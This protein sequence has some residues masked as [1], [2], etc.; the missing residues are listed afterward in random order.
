MVR[1]ETVHASEG[2]VNARRI[3][4]GTSLAGSSTSNSLAS[5]ALPS[6]TSA[7]HD[8]SAPETPSYESGS[9]SDAPPEAKKG[10]FGGLGTGLARTASAGS[11]KTSASGN[12]QPSASS[13]KLVE[14]FHL[15][16]EDDFD[17]EMLPFAQARSP[18]P[19]MSPP[20]TAGH[21]RDS[22]RSSLGAAFGASARPFSP[23]TFSAET[24][25]V[26]KDA[27]MIEL[28]SGAAVLEAKDYEILEWDTMQEIKKLATAQA[29][30]DGLE[31]DLRKISSR[32]LE[33]RTKL[34]RHT[35]GVLATSLRRK[36]EE[37]VLVG[38]TP[39]SPALASSSAA[40]SAQRRDTPSPTGSGS[41]ANNRF[42]GAHFFAG[43]REAIVPQARPGRG[44]PYASP[45]PD[46]SSFGVNSVQ[47]QHD[48]EE[49][50]ARVKELERQ[51]E[52]ATSR[53]E[54]DAHD[55][56]QELERTRLQ[57][58]EEQ[59][60]MR[61]HISEAQA[62]AEGLREELHAAHDDLEQARREAQEARDEVQA[63]RGLQGPS[64]DAQREIAAAKQDAQDAAR[65][66]RD[67]GM[68]LAEA[69]HKLG[70]AEE[71]VKELE[72]E[73]QRSGEERAD[74][75]NALQAKLDAATSASADAPGRDVVG[76]E[77]TEKAR[78][79]VRQLEEE[80]QSVMQAIGD[81]LRRHRTRPTLGVVLRDLPSF[82]DT[83]ERSDLPTYLA[84]TIDAHFDK[85]ASHVSDLSS[86]LSSLRDEHDSARSG[87]DDEL[88]HAHERIQAL[89]SDVE[90]LH[91]ERESLETEL[92]L[93][94][95]Q[96]QEHETKLANLPKLESD[97]ALATSAST[98]AQSDLSA[99]Q[100]RVADLE[101]QVAK[102]EQA[103]AKLQ[104]L[105]RGIPPLENRSRANSQSD[106][107]TV[108]KNA[109]EGSSPPL[110]PRKPIGA[111]LKTAIGA[112][113]GSVDA[114]SSD[115]SVDALVDRVKRLLAED[116]KLVKKLV[117][118]EN[119]KGELEE[120]RKKA[121]SGE[122]GLEQKVK[123]LEERIEISAKQEVAMLERL[124]DLTASLEQTRAEKRKLEAQIRTL[125]D[126]KSQLQQ[127]LSTAQ[128][129]P[130]A[131][132][133][134]T[135]ITDDTE[136]Q[137]LRDQIADLEEELADA[138]KREQK[139]RAQLLDELSQAQGE[140]STLK[141]QLRQAQRKLGSKA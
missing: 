3:F 8:H 85:S 25:A 31:A 83:T 61:R 52:E 9:T 133:N 63:H 2:A 131:A 7:S 113:G 89:E 23:E 100:G 122:A 44:S 109:F 118:F 74:E 22:S 19:P 49:Q 32:E 103:T 18:P 66:L 82:D 35:A 128:A 38:P 91:A 115:F 47:L 140:L 65:K 117:A 46:Q 127:Q 72:E 55:T 12:A 69:E 87:L 138:Q 129:T 21:R 13:S 110:P 43:N 58:H 27:L 132:D 42:S 98:R 24:A 60:R 120:M 36:E 78:Q 28:L 29:K 90:S 126:D 123:E 45:Q 62:D 48:L 94:R 15:D 97:L 130:P 6:P 57:A 37:Q 84:S 51:L 99:A 50:T 26:P 92:E 77:A 96:A 114:A 5:D 56:R 81:V 88:A 102:H 71:H 124:N 104:D 53:A 70:E 41:G 10:W 139:T 33:L 39:F 17:P 86:D 95:S 93:L 16:L 11:T 40:V 30:L 137:E 106:D 107:L 20:Q 101:A 136:L 64:E 54:R 119:E 79:R 108:L 134:T 68:E 59:D 76:T 111:F 105:W 67:L 116:Q 141:T 121:V 1:A 112:G 14:S 75:R 73:L 80:R 135:I 4:G 34:L 125:E